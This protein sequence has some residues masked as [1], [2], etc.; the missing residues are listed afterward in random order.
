MI[1]EVRIFDLESFTTL[2]DSVNPM[3]VSITDSHQ[4][5]KFAVENGENR[6]DHVIINPISID[7]ELLL[8]GD[9]ADRY[10][11]IKQLYDEHTLVGIQTRVKTYQPML[12]ESLTHDEDPQKVNAIELKLKFTEWKTIEPEYN[13]KSSKSTK[14]PK[15]TSTVN[16]GNVKSKKSTQAG[17]KEK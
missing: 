2:F 7:V 3:K 11:I 9:I 13:K 8:T 5:I 10:S 4:V 17:K 15:Q 12:L 6:S 14:K 16:R 1:T